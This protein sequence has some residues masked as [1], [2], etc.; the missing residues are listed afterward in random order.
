MSDCCKSMLIRNLDETYTGKSM[1]L[2]TDIKVDIVSLLFMNPNI[3]VITSLAKL[4]G[5]FWCF[6][7]LRHCLKV[8]VS[9]LQLSL[10]KSLKS[11]SFD[12]SG[13]QSLIYFSFLTKF[14]VFYLAL[15]K[16]YFS[17][18]FLPELSFFICSYHSLNRL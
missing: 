1:L 16:S 8:S 5:F 3:W 12:G 15:W 11:K 18:K 7:S 2:S 14:V 10:L 6:Y 13:K 17:T 4:R 9:T